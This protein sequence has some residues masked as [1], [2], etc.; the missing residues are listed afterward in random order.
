MI[1]DENGDQAP[2]EGLNVWQYSEDNP[3]HFDMVREELS[4]YSYQQIKY[5]ALDSDSK[6][7]DDNVFIE[8]ESRNIMIFPDGKAIELNILPYHERLHSPETILENTTVPAYA[9]EDGEYEYITPNQAL[10]DIKWVEDNT[11]KLETLSLGGKTDFY[12]RFGWWPHSTVAIDSTTFKPIS[13]P[14]LYMGTINLNWVKG[15]LFN[16]VSYERHENIH[17]PYS[18]DRIDHGFVLI[19]EDKL[20][21]PEWAEK[22]PLSDE[23]KAYYIDEVNYAE[24]VE[25]R[26][27]PV[28]KFPKIS[29]GAQDDETLDAPFNNFVVQIPVI[30]HGFEEYDDFYRINEGDLGT[31]TICTDGKGQYRAS[32]QQ[33]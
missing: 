10:W 29:I 30:Y 6:T 11:G 27:I 20:E 31:L 18:G 33:T 13:A 24:N 1:Y 12:D 28:D 21:I 9:D 5:A 4:K 7:L 15:Y 3:F 19:L 22:K 17:I 26:I 23:D 16:D 32:Y 2:F 8:Y 25:K 14:L